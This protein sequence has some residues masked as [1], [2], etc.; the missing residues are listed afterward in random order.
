M[1]GYVSLRH[2]RLGGD[3]IQVFKMIHGIDREN[4]GKLFCIDEGGRT[5][6][7]SLFKN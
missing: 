3:M 6:K 2:R 1:V 7:C 4:L 5:R